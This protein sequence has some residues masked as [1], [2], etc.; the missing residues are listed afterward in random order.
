LNK[1]S[2]N[3][4]PPPSP[5]GYRPD[6]TSFN[7]Y[8]RSNNQIVE[9]Y[10]K[11]QVMDPNWCNRPI[12]SLWWWNNSNVSP[13][14]PSYTL[15]LQITNNSVI[16][17]NPCTK[18]YRTIGLIRGQRPYVLI[19]DNLAAGP[20]TQLN[21]FDFTLHIPNDLQMAVPNKTDIVFQT[22][23]TAKEKML[24]K[25]IKADGI[26]SPPQ[27]LIDTFSNE[28]YRLVV[29]R[30]GINEQ[31]FIVLLFPYYDVAPENVWPVVSLVTNTLTITM[32]GNTDV[33]QLLPNTE[34]IFSRNGTQIINYQGQFEKLDNYL[35]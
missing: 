22:S 16:S 30:S 23:A 32:D 14:P 3:I 21:S 9:P 6:L 25:M 27:L 29:N 7:E 1:V 5:P 15:P 28:R 31:N 18:V 2:Q 33:F 19:F 17:Y 24:V 34:F 20:S 11:S 4:T 35:K 10:Q 8:R 12:W 26:Y 13:T